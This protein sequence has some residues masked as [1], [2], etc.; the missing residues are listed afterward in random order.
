MIVV[1]HPMAT[2][3]SQVGRHYFKAALVETAFQPR[4]SL[5][6]GLDLALDEFLIGSGFRTSLAIPAAAAGTAGGL[7][8]SAV[9]DG[10]GAA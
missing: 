6:A 7:D 8:P 9:L 2:L 5:P 1:A 3:I 10:A 4:R